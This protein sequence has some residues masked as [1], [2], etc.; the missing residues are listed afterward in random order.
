MVAMARHHYLECW[1]RGGGITLP[2][3]AFGD[4]WDHATITFLGSVRSDMRDHTSQYF[5]LGGVDGA[6]MM[7]PENL[8][9]F[10]DE[11]K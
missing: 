8:I 9:A 10:V 7:V 1:W 2:F 5:I 3:R 4:V 6:V 11:L